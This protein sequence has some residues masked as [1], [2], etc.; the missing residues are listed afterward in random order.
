MTFSLL[1]ALMTWVEK[2]VVK[3][4]YNDTK[5]RDQKWVIVAIGVNEV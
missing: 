2:K 1:L 3:K 5:C 4:T